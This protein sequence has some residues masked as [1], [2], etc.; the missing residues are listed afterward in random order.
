M[1]FIFFPFRTRNGGTLLS[2]IVFLKA[3]QVNFSGKMKVE[4]PE[5]N[6]YIQ[7]GVV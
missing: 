7:G 2:D 3:K 1:K 5:N 6:F 4:A